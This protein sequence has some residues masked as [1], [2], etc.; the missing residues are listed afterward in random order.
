MTITKVLLTNLKTVRDGKSVTLPANKAAD[1]NDEE[2]ELLDKLTKQT[3]RPHYRDPINESARA[4]AE[5]DGD[6]DGGLPGVFDGSTVPMDSKTVA[7]LKA[8]LD[9]NE[10]DYDSDANKA[11]LLKIAKAHEA[12]GGL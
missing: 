7:Q 9:H 8:Y 4:E 5:V 11:E 3:G 1:L 6:D 2:L 12:D 10:V